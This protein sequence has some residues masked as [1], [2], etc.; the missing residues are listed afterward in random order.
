MAGRS[1][2]IP[3]W[4]S[5]DK[6]A[7]ARVPDGAVFVAVPTKTNIGVPT[8]KINILTTF[9]GAREF[10]TSLCLGTWTTTENNSNNTGTSMQFCGPDIGKES[11]LSEITTE[12]TAQGPTEKPAVSCCFLIRLPTR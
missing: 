11:G 2:E 5:S 6:K 9:G 12:S 1:S 7:T 4:S 10:E 3:Q 8:L